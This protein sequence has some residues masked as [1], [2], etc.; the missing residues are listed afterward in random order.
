MGTGCDGS[1][2]A[3]IM[4]VNDSSNVYFGSDLQIN[5]LN[6]LGTSTLHGYGNTR[7][8]SVINYN[9]VVTPTLDNIVM[10]GSCTPPPPACQQPVCGQAITGN[11]VMCADLDCS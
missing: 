8:L 7:N 3:G 2:T 10:S 11:T 5:T 9:P 4:T 1:G 6:I